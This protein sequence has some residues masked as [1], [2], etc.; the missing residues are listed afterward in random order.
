MLYLAKFTKLLLHLKIIFPQNFNHQILNYKIFGDKFKL[1]VD[2]EIYLN[3]NF[4]KNGKNIKNGL[5]NEK[6]SFLEKTRLSLSQKE[7]ILKKLIKEKYFLSVKPFEK[8]FKNQEFLYDQFLIITKD[9]EYQ[10]YLDCPNFSNNKSNEEYF[11]NE[12][13]LVEEEIR[14][15]NL[16]IQKIEDE[17]NVLTD[18]INFFNEKIYEKGFGEKNFL[19]KK[20]KNF[21]NFR[22][23]L[24]ILKYVRNFLFEI[25]EEFLED[26]LIIKLK[27]SIFSES[28]VNI[29][30]KIE[31]INKKQV[32][33]KIDKINQIS[34]IYQTKENN[35][36]IENEGS[37]N[38][39]A[40]RVEE[41]IIVCGAFLT[42]GF[43]IFYYFFIETLLP[44]FY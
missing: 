7:K 44:F 1:N 14:T 31:K 40:N 43:L 4:I 32:C 22:K 8:L 9:F 42:F 35:Q 39:L 2:L 24:F 23:E 11:L 26:F 16:E 37:L 6:L 12:L 28:N 27:T 33:L 38:L 25:P 15:N 19:Y 17:K 10:K 29:L 21:Q 13:S 5:L 36:I 34:E 20:I 3:S 18:K 30:T 41:N